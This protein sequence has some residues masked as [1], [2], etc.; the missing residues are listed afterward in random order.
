MRLGEIFVDTGKHYLVYGT[1]LMA[2]RLASFVLIPIYTRA[3]PVEQYGVFAILTITLSV[4][5]TAAQLGINSAVLRSYFDYDNAKERAPVI[6]TAFLLLCG[7]TLVFA[8]AMAILSN[9]LSRL[10]T[11]SEQFA[12]C[13]WLLGAMLITDNLFN[14]YTSQLRADKRSFA[15]SVANGAKLLI[16]CVSAILL[17]AVL[18]RGIVGAV[19]A[20]C[21][22]SA[23]MCLAI[24]PALYKRSAFRFNSAE[25]KKL[26]AFGVPLVPMGLSAAVLAS[27]DR[28]FLLNMSG[29]IEV[30][31]AVVG[32]YSLIYMY[33][34][35]FRIGVVDPLFMVWLPQMLSVRHSDRAN[36]FYSRTL[37]F[38]VLFSGFIIYC[39][40]AAYKHVILFV[41]GRSYVG[42]TF[43]L[44]MILLSLVFIGATRLVG[45][46]MTFARKTVYSAIFY[47]GAG[48]INTALNFLL[49]PRY[50]ML[51]AAIAT[52]V[53]AAI[54]PICYHRAGQKFHSVDYRWSE[55]I[56]TA[57]IFFALSTC[58]F[59]LPQL[60]IS[61]IRRT[62]AEASLGALYFPL[63]FALGILKP[64]EIR[65]VLQYVRSRGS[66]MAYVNEGPSEVSST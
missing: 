52:V 25:A 31:K 10:I 27:A 9:P 34:N 3:L 28:Y 26:L 37:S 44:W 1:G 65:G 56:R 19:T 14:L 47:T 32:V 4:I 41:S 30:G 5:S 58:Y 21:V 22:S 6:G 38:Y 35:V 2:S 40:T 50:G 39:L 36:E 48:A 24:M 54:L 64:A 42:S 17:V 20:N 18:K 51:G 55:I 29:S 11:G 46:G 59:A 53:G 63:A 7:S 8:A 12:I 57:M 43:V 49:I 16:T 61:G 33:A 66:G 62:A 23:L 45:V 60:G 15:F 13:L